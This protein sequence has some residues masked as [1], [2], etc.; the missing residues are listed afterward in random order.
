[1]SFGNTT[2]SFS[3][4][5]SRFLDF[6]NA[7]VSVFTVSAFGTTTIGDGTTNNMASLQIGY[8]GICV[9]N[10]GTCTATSTGWVVADGFAAGNSD[11]A[12]M[13][14]S[15]T[16]LETGEVVMLDGGLSVDRADRTSSQA[17]IGVVST[18]P[19]LTIGSDDTSDREGETGY[20]IALSG[21][22]PVKL[23]TENGP[24]E[25]GDALMLSNIPGVAMK[26]KGTGT[27]IGI[28]LEDFDDTRKYSDT[29]VNQFGD[30][31]VEPVFEPITTNTDPRIDD[32]CYYSGGGRSGEEPC[33]PLFATTSLG[34]IEEANELAE[35][36]SIVE[37][38]EDL[39]NTPSETVRVNGETVRVGQIVM[40][41]KLQ[42]R[43]VD[44]SQLAALGILT[45]SSSIDNLAE[46]ETLLDRLVS[47]AESFIDG[48]LSVFEVRTNRVE[49]ADE[50][51]I[52]GTC[53]DGET[54]R[55]LIDTQAAAVSSNGS[56][57]TGVSETADTTGTTSGA[58]A[59]A[60]ANETSEETTD[61]SASTSTN[62]SST[63]SQAENSTSTN[64]GVSDTEAAVDEP[65]VPDN[66][67][68]S[69]EQETAAGVSEG[70]TEGGT[71]SEESEPS[72]D[73]VT[74]AEV[75]DGAAAEP[76]A[77]EPVEEPNTADEADPV[78]TEP[79]ESAPAAPDA[80]SDS[81]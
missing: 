22:V 9:D 56:D 45:S 61:T 7:G 31:L 23:S 1:M 58:E 41:V 79:T 10:D 66:A 62:A 64:D 76:E 53:I 28:A 47:L 63:D 51:C 11:L 30:S 8:G 16:A 25:K 37:Q 77:E 2:G 12:E 3:S 24:I 69:A 73:A 68:T 81:N 60:A 40:F 6:Q 15:S 52:D 26:A 70:S 71:T 33:T 54:L 49:V 48:V 39:R 13:Y 55:T 17:V 59:G 4:S 29:Y 20:P 34:V 42:E 74:E 67:T 36:E 27:I 35:Q 78:D 38:L 44:E 14:F 46:D 43:L 32:G 57:T 18:E 19:G 75:S 5:T 72:S 50:I 21:R 80:E 65:V